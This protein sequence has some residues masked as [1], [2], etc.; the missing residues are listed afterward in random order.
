MLVIRVVE[1]ER[2][3]SVGRLVRV[4]EG[5]HDGRRR[6][7]VAGDA[8]GSQRLG[9][10]REVRPVHAVCTP[11][12][13]RR[14]RQLRLWSQW[15]TLHAELQQRIA[16]AAVGSI[17]VRLAGGDWIHTLGQEVAHGVIKVGRM[18]CIVDGGREA[19]GAATLAIDAAEE[20]DTK[21]RGQGAAL[22]IG[23]DGMT[24][25][26]MTR[27]LCWRRIGHG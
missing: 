25:N 3:L 23:T 1:G 17:A 21:I 16:T 2:L 14:T 9:Q 27:Q 4:I 24:S 12:E 8:V 22:D 7:R 11:R 15:G 18:A 10:P 13:G 19:C 5:E 26:G 6:L 20:E